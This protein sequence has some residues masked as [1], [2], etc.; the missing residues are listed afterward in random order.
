MDFETYKLIKNH[1]QLQDVE[2]V[3]LDCERLSGNNTEIKIDTQRKIEVIDEKIVEI[4]LRVK[5][6]AVIL[7][8]LL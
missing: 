6:K 1:V 4:Y 8:S 2:L 5:N 7:T 3:S